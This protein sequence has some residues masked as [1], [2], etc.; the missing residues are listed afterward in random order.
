MLGSAALAAPAG[1]LGAAYGANPPAT[2][3][4]GSTIKVPITL[5]NT[6]DE[7]WNAA[8]PNPVNLS[9]H[10]Y[11]GGASSFDNFRIRTND[12]AFI[13]PATAATADSEAPAM[14]TG[15]TLSETELARVLADAK[16]AWTASGVDPAAFDGVRVVLADLS[17]ALLG[18]TAGRTIYIDATAAGHGW[19]ASALVPTTIAVVRSHLTV[20]GGT[21]A[22][23]DTFITG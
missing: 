7:T 2:A 15:D 11:R 9:Y 13:A 17:G 18:Q 22:G 3:A 8:A 12:R 23:V 20:S 10:W 6:G 16:R 5:L 1:V 21:V 4:A 19:T 14:S